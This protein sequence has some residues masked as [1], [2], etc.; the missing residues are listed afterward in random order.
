MI[1]FYFLSIFFNAVSGYILAMEGPKEEPVVET[2]SQ[3]SLNNETIR[4]ILGILTLVSG[5]LKLL[6]ATQGDIPVIGD[7]L[8]AVF[9]LLAGFILIFDYYHTKTSVESEKSELIER[10]LIKNKRWIGF[11]AIASAVLHFLFPSVLF[12]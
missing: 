6:S 5:L 11:V 9:G 10:V 2:G 12:L 1:Q 4:L 3:F 7:L 8:P